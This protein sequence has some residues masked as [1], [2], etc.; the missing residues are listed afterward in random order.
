MSIAYVLRPAFQP[1]ADI[2]ARCAG[3]FMNPR[4]DAMLATLL[5]TFDLHEGEGT[6]RLVLAH[7][8]TRRAPSAPSIT[9]EVVN[10]LDEHPENIDWPGLASIAHPAAMSLLKQHLAS[11][12]PNV[13]QRM[14]FMLCQNNCPEAVDIVEQAIADPT[15]RC[16]VSWEMLSR[17]PSATHIFVNDPRW[18]EH[19]CPR[20]ILSNSSELALQFIEPLLPQLFEEFESNVAR[21]ERLSANPVIF[22]PVVSDILLK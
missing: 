13:V 3:L 20:S 16:Y 5:A 7:T 2:F 17:N 22:E 18:R 11:V 8:A 21:W 12:P 6:G 9:L 14:Y 19:I 1:Y 10:A 15:L 4:A